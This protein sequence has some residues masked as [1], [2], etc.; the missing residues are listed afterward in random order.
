MHH[1][2]MTIEG[3]CPRCGEHAERDSVDVGVGIIHGPWGCSCCGW[4]ESEQYDLSFGGGVQE[5]GSYLDPMGGYWPVG[6]PVV[7]M[8]KAAEVGDAER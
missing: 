8:M 5:S 1:E 2:S 6:N 7:Q 3:I 4:S